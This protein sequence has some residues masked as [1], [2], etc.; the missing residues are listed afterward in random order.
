MKLSAKDHVWCSHKEIPIEMKSVM[1]KKNNLQMVYGRDLGIFTWYLEPKA[2]R[3]YRLIREFS[4]LSVDLEQTL[5]NQ[6]TP[7]VSG[8]N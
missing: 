6:V 4:N 7:C 1:Y 2:Q 5:S 3:F 8:L